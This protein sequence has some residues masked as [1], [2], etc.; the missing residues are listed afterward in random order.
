[1]K[2][3]V[4][5]HYRANNAFQWVRDLKPDDIGDPFEWS[6]DKRIEYK[7]LA[8]FDLTTVDA[9]PPGVYVVYGPCP[10]CGKYVANYTA[11]EREETFGDM[12]DDVFSDRDLQG[13]ADIMGFEGI[14]DVA[15]FLRDEDENNNL[16][17][18]Y[19]RMQGN[20]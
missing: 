5:Y 8:G 18:E 4:K 12:L 7:P 13:I 9:N 17:N 10:L 16:P 6:L 11:H 3:L 20:N 19:N 15:D 1:M 2:Y 14:N